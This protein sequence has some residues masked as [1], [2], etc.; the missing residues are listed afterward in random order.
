MDE[1]S[2]EIAIRILEWMACSCRLLKVYEILDGIVFIPNCTTLNE[3]TK[4]RRQVLNLCQ[5]LIEDGP[6]D[7]V[8]FVHFSAK[9]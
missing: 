5:P 3:G 6:S 8:D 9:R 7:T 1:S 4:Y 2:C